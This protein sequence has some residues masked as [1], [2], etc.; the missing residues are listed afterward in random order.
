[1]HRVTEFKA[2]QDY[3]LWLR[4]DDGMEG[5]GAS[6]WGTFLR[7]ALFAGGAMSNGF[8]VWRSIR[9][10]QRWSGMAESGWIPTFC[11]R[12]CSRAGLAKDSVCRG[13][14]RLLNSLRLFG[15]V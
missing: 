12:T 4:F 10:R 8:A 13:L 6:F 5:K 14:P 2:S 7:S 1:M 11:T 9:P 3:R 15:Q